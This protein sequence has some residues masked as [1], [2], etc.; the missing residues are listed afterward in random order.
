MKYLVTLPL[1]AIFGSLLF[2]CLY[3]WKRYRSRMDLGDKVAGI[4]LMS[5]ILLII[6]AHIGFLLAGEIEVVRIKQ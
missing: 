6:L 4:L 1:I 5:V 2:C 3:T